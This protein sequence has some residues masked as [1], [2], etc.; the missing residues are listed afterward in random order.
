MNIKMIS[1]NSL[2]SI[3]KFI[4]YIVLNKSIVHYTLDKFDCN[5]HV[6][7]L[8]IGFDDRKNQIEEISSF[9]QN[10]DF[11][12]VETVCFIN[13]FK[14]VNDRLDDLLK[15]C[16][17][18]NLNIVSQHYSCKVKIFNEY[19]IPDYCLDSALGYIVDMI[20]LVEEK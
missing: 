1:C 13:T 9:L 2:K 7:L 19:N 6:D 4:D 3:E 20:Q 16:S 10:T 12:K 5:E 17:N 18:K 8:I 15:I 14:Y 11:K